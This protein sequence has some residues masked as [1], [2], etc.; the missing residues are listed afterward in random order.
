MSKTAFEVDTIEVAK[1]IEVQL[2]MKRFAEW[3]IRRRIGVA[4]MRLGLRITGV[5][6]VVKFET[7]DSVHLEVID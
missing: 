1:R 4:L 3:E 7:D 2:T 6:V 5:S